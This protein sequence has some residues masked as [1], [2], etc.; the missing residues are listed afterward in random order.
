MSNTVWAM[1]TLSLP[2]MR[3][4]EAVAE[5]AVQRGMDCFYPQAISN[6]VWA[7][8]VLEYNNTTF[9]TVRACAASPA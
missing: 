7:F 6:M 1:A 3:L 4:C 2:N 5:E 8:A 9:M